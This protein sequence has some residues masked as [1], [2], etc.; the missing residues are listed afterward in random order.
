MDDCR[1]SCPAVPVTVVTAMLKYCHYHQTW[2]VSV[3]EAT[4]D[5]D[6]EM[7]TQVDECLTLGPLYTT[8]QAVQLLGGWVGEALSR[9]GSPW[10]H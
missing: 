5:D 7:T 1:L 10:V 2:T 8:E 9:P 6:S 4:Q 3:W